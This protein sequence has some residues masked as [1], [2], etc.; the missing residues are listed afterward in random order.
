MTEDDI[1]G[2]TIDVL[3]RMLFYA[4]LA[5]EHGDQAHME[6]TNYEKKVV[7]TIKKKKAK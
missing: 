6:S 2:D 1:T 4:Q 5:E 3:R 7:I